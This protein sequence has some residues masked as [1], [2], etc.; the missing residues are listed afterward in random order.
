MI[1]YITTFVLLT[2]LG[3]LYEKYKLKYHPDEELSKYDLI[4]IF[5]QYF[6]DNKIKVIMDNNYKIDKSLICTRNDFNY[7][8]SSYSDMI[9]KMKQWMLDHNENYKH[10]KYEFSIS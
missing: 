10:Y 7:N 4:N 6:R 3:I 9:F 2:V 5:N 1:K 8:V